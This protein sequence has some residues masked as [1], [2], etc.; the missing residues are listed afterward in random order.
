MRWEYNCNEWY[1]LFSWLSWW[2]SKLP[3]L[4]LACKSP[5]WEWNLHQFYCS[6]NRTHLWLH[7]CMVSQHCSFCL[8]KLWMQLGQD[9]NISQFFKLQTT[10]WHLNWHDKWGRQYGFL[11]NETNMI[12]RLENIIQE[13]NRSFMSEKKIKVII[14]KYL[15]Q[16]IVIICLQK[17]ST[18]KIWWNI[19]S[20][21]QVIIVLCGY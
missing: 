12:N 11:Q 20:S 10:I 18:H 14:R 7:Y 15:R 17:S 4:F 3:R 2:V 5:P 16:A 9:E 21:I 6:S 13:R 19:R 8:I 1:H